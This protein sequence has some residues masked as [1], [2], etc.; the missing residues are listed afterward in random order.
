MRGQRNGETDEQGRAGRHFV[1]NDSCVDISHNFQRRPAA[2]KTAPYL[3]RIHVPEILNQLEK[4]LLL[5][6]RADICRRRS[7]HEPF[8]RLQDLAAGRRARQRAQSWPGF[9]VCTRGQENVDQEIQGSVCT[10]QRQRLGQRLTRQTRM[11]LPEGMPERRE[12]L[13]KLGIVT[14]F[15]GP[16]DRSKRAHDPG[17]RPHAAMG[18]VGRAHGGE[19]PRVAR[20][21]QP[22]FPVANTPPPF[23]KLSQ[24]FAGFVITLVEMACLQE[25]GKSE[26]QCFSVWRPRSRETR[27]LGH[28]QERNLIVLE[29]HG[30]RHCFEKRLILPS[31][32]RRSPEHPALLVKAKRS[33]SFD[34]FRCLLLIDLAVPPG[35]G[36][37]WWLA[38][39]EANLSDGLVLAR[40][41]EATLPSFTDKHMKDDVFV[42]S[43]PGMA[44][45]LPVFDV[46]IDLDIP[47]ELYSID[48]NPSGAE[49]RPRLTVPCSEVNDFYFL[50][51]LAPPRDT[52]LSAKDPRLQ[53]E[54]GDARRRGFAQSMTCQVAAEPVIE[55]FRSCFHVQFFA[56]AR[57][58]GSAE[59]EATTSARASPAAFPAAANTWRALNSEGQSIISQADIFWQEQ[60]GL[61]VSQIVAHMSEIRSPGR[62]AFGSFD[63]LRHGH[64]GCVGSVP[65]GI[66][67]Q[68]VNSPRRLLGVP[69]HLFAVG[70]ISQQ[71]ASSTAENQTCCHC[72]PVGQIKWDDLGFTKPKRA[73]DH[74]RLRPNIGEILKFAPE[75]IF[76][77]A[78]QIV[79]RAFPCI[80]GHELVFHF[81]EPSQI[82]ETENMVRVRMRIDHGV[83]ACERFAQALRAKIRR[84]VHLD[85]H[86]RRPQLYRAAQALVSR[87]YRRTDVALAADHRDPVRR[88][89]SEKSNFHLPHSGTFMA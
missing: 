14:G 44:V 88:A 38:Q 89:R 35:S 19:R 13:H 76:K 5:H 48:D 75:R 39:S 62:D 73:I 32:A 58:E 86:F 49:V 17:K 6:R 18:M 10:D 31:Q 77:D 60:L 23:P 21:D 51:V 82:I 55:V 70:K 26:K 67:D 2:G 84:R 69:G 30:R 42:G 63:G 66:D 59:S 37:L 85:H 22:Q 41:R 68:S 64:M 28:E 11:P 74:N 52:K 47:G 46:L 53:L 87:V 56:S 54:F 3:L 9:L 78:P 40:A 15:D 24:I 8:Q 81:A 71:L 36:I 12:N 61:N 57:D 27:T 79:E 43:V 33:G 29:S 7:A 72:S 45:V 25:P 50:S 83:D 34:Q 65:Q 80:D 16:F 4:P 1:A 20:K